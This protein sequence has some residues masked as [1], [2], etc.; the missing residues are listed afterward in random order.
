VVAY[1][2]E[3]HDQDHE[4]IRKAV[5]VLARPH[6]FGGT[7]LEYMTWG[8]PEYNADVLL[9]PLDEDEATIKAEAVGMYFSQVRPHGHYDELYAYSPASVRSY[10]GATGRLVHTPFAEAF[11]PR[12]I[13]PNETTAA[14]L[15]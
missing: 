15:G 13:V 5:Q 14:L 12:R 1:P 9:L 4:A 6:R 3:S 2:A 10:L 8:V 7:L 11:R